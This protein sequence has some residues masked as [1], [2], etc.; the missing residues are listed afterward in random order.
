MRFITM[1]AAT[2]RAC[3]THYEPHFYPLDGIR[4]W[5]RIYG[6]RGFMQYQCVVPPAEAAQCIQRLA[7]LIAEAVA[8]RSWPCSRS[9][10]SCTR[11]ACY[12]SR[13]RVQH[14]R[15]ISPTRQRTLQLLDRLDDIVA[16]AGGAVYP[17]KDARMPGRSFRQYFPAWE[18]FSKYIDPRFSSS[19]WRR[20]M[21]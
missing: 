18:C 17:A 3:D 5:N 10:P 6:P 11:L 4:D 14:W 7:R 19:F 20:V 8:V 1:A 9:S 16:T 13:V 2:G 21:E 15:W 12:H